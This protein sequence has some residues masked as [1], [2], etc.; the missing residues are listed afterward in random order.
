M[1]EKE[2]DKEQAEWIRQS[3]QDFGLDVA[4]LVPYRVRVSFPSKTRPSAVYMLDSNGRSDFL[5]DQNMQSFK[6]ANYIF[7]AGIA[8]VL[9]AIMFEYF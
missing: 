7:N 5:R 8:E 4:V 6:M 9:F 3:F 1:N 2:S